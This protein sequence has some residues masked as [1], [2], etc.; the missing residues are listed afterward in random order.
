MKNQPILLNRLLGLSVEELNHTKIRISKNN[1]SEDAIQVFKESPELVNTS[2]LLWREKNNLFHVGD[3]AIHLVLISRD[4]YLLT[5]V[6]TITKDLGKHGDVAYE[7][8]EWSNL[9][10]FY[11]RVIVSY[12]R[13]SA[14]TVFHAV[15]IMEHL[16]VLEVLPDMYDDD[17]FP[18]YDNVRI[19]YRQL[20]HILDRRIPDWIAALENQKG[21]YL[22]TDLC[23]G[24]LYVGSATAERG[25]LL[26]RWENY[27]QDG[28]GGDVALR[29]LIK[30]EGI[31][32]VR[33]NFQYSILE[34]YNARID[35]AKI[36]VRETWWKLT[37]GS[38]SEVLG[39][40][41]N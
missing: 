35:D 25:M 1:E 38:R 27:A 11:G 6:K 32:Y 24:K 33:T 9:S 36:L 26:S 17:R 40:N 29:D 3:I 39:Y 41:R 7:G 34:N 19:T 21:V 14:G 12:H 5:T 28:H 20:S 4:R 30:N 8:E 37:L 10:Q 31:N 22:I 18:G 23:S 16:E 15:T 13:K 2:W